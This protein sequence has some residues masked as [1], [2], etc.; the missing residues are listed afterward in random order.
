MLSRR[1]F[2]RTALAAALATSLPASRAWSA[3]LSQSGRVDGD[4]VA[5][6]GDGKSVTL[7]S[8]DIASLA[9]ALRGNL[10][11][12]GHA[13]YDPARRV[14]NRQMDKFPALIVQPRGAADVKLAVD[15]ARA[16]NLL[17]AVKCGGHSP[18]DRKS[19]V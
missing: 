3:L 9:N 8:A 15:F 12:R 14:L 19:V 2:A 10:V 11:L 18:S 7:P 1:Q 13:A 5:V 16:S 17:V 4:I 6:T